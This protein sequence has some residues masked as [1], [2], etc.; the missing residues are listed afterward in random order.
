MVDSWVPTSVMEVVSK[1]QVCVHTICILYHDE[2]RDHEIYR[3]AV[4]MKWVQLHTWSVTCRERHG[5]KQQ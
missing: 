4:R 2:Y 5:E 1:F 3:S